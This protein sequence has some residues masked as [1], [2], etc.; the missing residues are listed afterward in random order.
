[1]HPGRVKCEAPAR[2]NQ[3]S[4]I[5]TDGLAMQIGALEVK[6]AYGTQNSDGQAFGT[7]EISCHRL[8]LVSSDG[9]HA[10]GNF[11]HGDV[12]AK[13]HSLPSHITHAAAGG[14]QTEQQ[15]S[16]QIILGSLQFFL[17]NRVWL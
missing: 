16:L 5:L 13:I 14:F 12:T 10:S 2:R 15:A 17:A 1:M 6:A 7:E 8:H 4:E 3:S 9:V 11:V